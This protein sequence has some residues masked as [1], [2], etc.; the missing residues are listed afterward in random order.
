AQMLKESLQDGAKIEMGGAVRAEDK[1][2]SPTVLSRVSL[3]SSV[4]QEEIFGPILPVI[5]Y[6]NMDEVIE[7]INSK[8]KPLALYIFSKSDENIERI[9]SK[10]ASG[11]VCINDV[12]L[13]YLHLNLPF[14]GI[15]NS[16]HGNSH[17]YYGFK[18]FSHERAILKHGPFSPL[19]LMYPPYT[20]TVQKFVDL[21]LKYL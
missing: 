14:G 11:G 17:G 21:T 15:G 16:G 5:P 6:K 19:K 8:E 13:H 2:I 7:I 9:L 20:K 18:A 12:V 1:Y 10:T 3:D 4:M